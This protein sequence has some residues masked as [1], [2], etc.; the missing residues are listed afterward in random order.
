LV[1]K[2]SDGGHVLPRWKLSSLETTRG[3]IFSHETTRPCKVSHRFRSAIRMRTSN[4]FNVCD[5]LSSSP[6]RKPTSSLSSLYICYQFKTNSHPKFL[7][8]EYRSKYSLLE[9][10]SRLFPYRIRYACQTLFS[11][12][13][14]ELT[15]FP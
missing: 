14:N 4:A 9:F 10:R 2:L 12:E 7:R 1:G 15:E 11:F 8:N 13:F 3:I 6:E 5:L